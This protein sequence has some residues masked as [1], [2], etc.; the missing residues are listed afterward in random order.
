MDLKLVVFSLAVLCVVPA[1]VLSQNT[2]PPLA[3]YMYSFGEYCPVCAVII[4]FFLTILYNT[5]L[6]KNTLIF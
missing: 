4:Q 6:F 5:A 2:C 1:K 3:E